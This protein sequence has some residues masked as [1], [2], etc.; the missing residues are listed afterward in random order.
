MIRRRIR[1]V[2]ISQRTRISKRNYSVEIFTSSC[3]TDSSDVSVSSCAPSFSKSSSPCSSPPCGFDDAL[4]L[5]F[6]LPCPP[7]LLLCLPPLPLEDRPVGCSAGSSS[8][9]ASSSS[10]SPPPLP[11]PAL[12]C[13]STSASLS[14]SFITSSCVVLC[15]NSKCFSSNKFDACVSMLCFSCNCPDVSSFFPF[16][17]SISSW[18]LLS[19]SLCSASTCLQCSLSNTKSFEIPLHRLTID[20]RWLNASAWNRRKQSR[21]PHANARDVFPRGVV[22]V[23]PR[24]KVISG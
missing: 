19:A 5:L 22:V 13:P 20:C 15:S 23:S 11:L 17:L 2:R 4:F 8:L 24:G 14:A 21:N 18:T 16:K 3:V 1:R 9:K 10:S 7:R 12:L 6:L